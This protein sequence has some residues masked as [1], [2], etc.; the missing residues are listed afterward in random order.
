M[1]PLIDGG[2]PITVLQFRQCRDGAETKPVHSMDSAR[3][4]AMRHDDDRQGLTAP[5]R[6]RRD[7]IT[8]G[9]RTGIYLR[10][11]STRDYW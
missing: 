5:I 4:A 2:P 6:N 10:D 9:Q 8:T 3:T 11:A 7:G 1:F